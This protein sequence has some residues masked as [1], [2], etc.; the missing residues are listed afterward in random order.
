MSSALAVHP[1]PAPVP[2]APTPKLTNTALLAGTGGVLLLAPLAFGAVEPWAIFALEACAVLLL[3]A[4]GV[5]QWL[6]Q[7]I[8]FSNNVL[9]VPM[10]A[11]LVLAVVQWITGATAYRHVTYAQILLYAAYGMLA[12]VATQSLRRSS[13]FEWLA[14][15]VT[16]YG[17]LLA[18]FAVL[19]GIAPNGK[20]YWMMSSAQ[21][22]AIYG[23]YV[24]HNHYAGLMEMLTPFPLI[25]AA[26][27]FTNGNRR[28]I[29]TTIAALMAGSIFLS[30]SR[31]GMLA[32][33]AQMIV[34]AVLFL[35]SRES[36]WKKPLVLGIFL[37]VVI[38][39]LVWLGGN[40]L[41]RRL[42]S[43]HS[44]AH[45]E[46]SGGT[47][48]TIDRD[49][50]R[51]F[52]KRPFLGWGL[53]SFPIVYPQFRSFYTTFFVNQAHNDY[54]QLLVETGLA[55]FSIAVL[56]LVLMFRQG[57]AK[58]K[59]WNETSTG[60]LT[61]AAFLGCLGILVHSA[62]DFNLQIPANAALFYVLCAIVAA[63]PLHESQRRRILRR[64]SA[65]IEIAPE[66]KPS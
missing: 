61:A 44:E 10:G 1:E 49:C 7:Q 40:E 19:Q 53:G 35:R 63:K 42:A 22:G 55:G 59:D 43:I 15:V 16:G 9:Y 37:L 5:R 17:A 27:R 36:N 28:I 29:V 41:T 50:L 23:P 24:N 3:L 38:A 6:N 31:G 56:F 30:G 2:K 58:L 39:F 64:R 21:G 33:S 60:A 26:S 4:W 66:T 32:F 47:R 65:I 11:F 52:L 57:M 12:F 25:L 14:K 20:L 48:L 62:V 18:G 51:M 46:I 13:H 54:L 8:D 45:A 34:L